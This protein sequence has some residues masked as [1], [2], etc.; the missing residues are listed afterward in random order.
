MASKQIQ[1]PHEKFLGSAIKI[2]NGI[3]RGCST[4][5]D[6]LDFNTGAI[7]NVLVLDPRHADNAK[8]EIERAYAHYLDA[9]RQGR[10]HKNQLE[11]KLIP[12]YDRET[13]TKI[14]SYKLTISPK[15]D[16]A[17]NPHLEPQYF[18]SVLMPLVK[19]ANRPKSSQIKESKA[20]QDF[21]DWAEKHAKK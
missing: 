10:Q 5:G 18:L 4:I 9:T 16:A 15:N 14:T 12:E 3:L 11:T 21:T 6:S 19:E 1:T 7:H 2:S 8:Q 13:Q 20:W 17:G